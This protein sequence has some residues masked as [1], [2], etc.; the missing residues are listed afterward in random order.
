MNRLGVKTLFIEREN[1]WEDDYRVS[2][3]GTLRD[4]IL[5]REIFSTLA[6]ARI[7]M[8]GWRKE[9]NQLQ[10]HSALFYAGYK[11]GGRAHVDHIVEID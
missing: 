1:P 4:E 11:K 9:Y 2:F 5:N 7:L 10:A 3:N 6:E 8:E